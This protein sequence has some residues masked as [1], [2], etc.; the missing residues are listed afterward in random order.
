MPSIDVLSSEARLLELALKIKNKKL[1]R[2]AKLLEEA[3]AELEEAIASIVERAELDPT[4]LRGTP[5]LLRDMDG[6]P[7]K[8]VWRDAP[9]PRVNGAEAPEAN[10]TAAKT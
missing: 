1:K 5:R 8:L 9:K 10:A 4:S 7:A 2:A 6:K 3:E